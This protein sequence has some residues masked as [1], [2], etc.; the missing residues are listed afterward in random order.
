LGAFGQVPQLFANMDTGKVASLLADS[1]T[2]ETR[3]NIKVDPSKKADYVDYE[4]SEG[5]KKNENSK[6]ANTND[7]I[8][9][10]DY[11]DTGIATITKNPAA[12]V[13]YKISDDN[14]FTLD[15]FLK[16]FQEKIRFC[17][18]NMNLAWG[19]QGGCNIYDF[20]TECAWSN[21]ICWS[22]ENLLPFFFV[23]SL[24]ATIT[25]LSTGTVLQVISAAGSQFLGG[26]GDLIGA[27][28]GSGGLSD[29]AKTLGFL[30][31]RL[32]EPILVLI[33]VIAKAFFSLS[34]LNFLAFSTCFYLIYYMLRKLLVLF[35]EVFLQPLTFF[36]QALYSGMRGDYKAY[37]SALLFFTNIICQFALLGSFIEIISQFV[38]LLAPIMISGFFEVTLTVRAKFD[39]L[40]QII[41]ELVGYAIIS[42]LMTVI[43]ATAAYLYERL[44]LSLQSI[45][46][47]QAYEKDGNFMA[48][49]AMVATGTATAAQ[50]SQLTDAVVKASATQAKRMAARDRRKSDSK[51]D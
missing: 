29:I 14:N 30:F 39:M 50:L 41:F 18:P 22:K 11:V 27:I 4:I 16:Y 46:K 23:G 49:T 36:F 25:L 34:L 24:E 35:I 40:T 28:S 8:R 13:G 38:N 51:T 37:E 5:E 43:V 44:S 6:D 31:E 42:L 3:Y 20:V 2:I 26:S 19:L 32:I 21:K 9:L 48:V 7:Y 47:Q 17:T 33:G 45:F 10:F 12:V 15:D 1:E